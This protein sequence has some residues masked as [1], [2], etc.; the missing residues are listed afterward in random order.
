MSTDSSPSLDHR[1]TAPGVV[2]YGIGSSFLVDIEESLARNGV[3]IVAGVRNQDGENFLSRGPRIIE[4]IAV[5][6]DIKG[7][8]FLVPFFSPADRQRVVREALS[9][10]FTTPFTLIDVSAITPRDLRVD[11]GGYVNAGCTFGAR[12]ACAEFVTINRGTTLGHHVNLGRFVSLG[13]GVVVAGH[14]TVGKGSVIGAGA[15]VLPNVSIGENAVIAAGAVV[16]RD[17]PDGRL[18]VGNPA[19]IIKTVAGYHEMSVE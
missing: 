10:G 16:T 13:P 1:Q 18:V 6:D 3:D 7:V 2:I 11:S 5:P 19:R 9:I 15:V 8:P 17:V 4:S 12:S 14:V